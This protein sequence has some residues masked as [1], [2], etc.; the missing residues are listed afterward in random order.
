M[1]I[2]A[3]DC[4]SKKYV[5]AFLASLY[6]MR[7]MCYPDYTDD[8]EKYNII[9]AAWG[10]KKSIEYCKKFNLDYTKKPYNYEY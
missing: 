2:K 3:T 8:V 5:D 10:D 7:S 4:W 6:S 9:S 1:D